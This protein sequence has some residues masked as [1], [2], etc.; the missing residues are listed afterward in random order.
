VGTKVSYTDAT[1][2]IGTKYTYSVGAVIPTGTVAGTNSVDAT[3]TVVAPA[4]VNVTDTPTGLTV[5]WTDMSNNETGFQIVRNIAALAINS[6]T[7]VLE[8]VLDVAGLPTA[9]PG[10]A[11][12]TAV[13]SSATQKT[14]TNAAR[15][16][17]D[18]T[19]VPGV[20]YYY[21]VASTGGVTPSAP[22]YSAPLTIADKTALVPPSAPT[23]VITKTAITVTWTDLSTN[24]TGFV[25]QRLFT[26]A[27]PAVGAA[28]PA[29]TTLPTPA[30]TGAATTGVNGA[31]TYTDKVAAPAGYGTY[32]YQV[33]AVNAAGATTP[34]TS[35]VVDFTL[36]AAPTG[37]SVTAGAAGSGAVTLGWTDVATNE[38]G[39][40]IQRATNATFTKGLVSTAVPGA[41]VG[42][43]TS[44]TLNG[45]TPVGTPYFYRVAATNAVGTSAY[46][47]STV[48]VAVP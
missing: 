28:L 41:V 35:N 36:P 24:E 19:V 43:N 38:T 23:A 7:G 45:L 46:V 29:W 12:T 6:A 37:L 1:A 5:S 44:Y 14:A 15:T 16:Y 22:V 11:L 26:P 47:A 40:T 10:S 33:S 2:A 21:T 13:A 3:L 20:T 9:V 18:T 8:P 34:L 25:L 17:I 32:Q 31:V 30:R 48:A 4:N 42:G 27:A 39:Y